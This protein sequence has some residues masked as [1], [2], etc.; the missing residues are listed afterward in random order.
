MT[1]CIISIG[2]VFPHEINITQVLEII[3]PVQTI[4]SLHLVNGLA[5]AYGAE[6]VCVVYSMEMRLA[7]LHEPLTLLELGKNLQTV[8]EFVNFMSRN[9]KKT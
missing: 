4:K 1:D 5:L 9:D 8:V 6:G 3:N 7:T 2:I